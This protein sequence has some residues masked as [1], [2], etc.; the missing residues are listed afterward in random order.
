[1]RVDAPMVLGFSFGV[2]RDHDALASETPAGL[3]DEFG[4]LD[5]ACVDGN[6]VATGFEEFPD[7]LDL[8]DA[9]P[10][11]ERDKDRG[12]HFLGD[13]DHGAAFFMGSRDVEEDQ[14]IRLLLVVGPGAGH[15]ITGV[16][17]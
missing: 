14:L 8:M 16:F 6:L 7:V 4:I 11:G 13:F 9:S 1:M 15:G 5:G 2:D 10:D 3:E 12:G 17:Q